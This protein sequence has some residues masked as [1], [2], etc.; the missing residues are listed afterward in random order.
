MNPGLIKALQGLLGIAALVC[1]S[2]A[3]TN[4]FPQLT[5]V[6]AQIASGITLWLAPDPKKLFQK[7]PTVT[8]D[9]QVDPEVK[10]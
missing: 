2:L 10:K 9:V 5:W 1:G 4:T 7:K 3:A 8:V 6:L